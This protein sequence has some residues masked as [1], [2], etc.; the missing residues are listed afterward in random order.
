MEANLPNLQWLS[1]GIDPGIRIVAPKAQRRKKTPTVV[2]RHFSRSD[3]EEQ[4]IE[5]FRQLG[6]I[7]RAAVV[8]IA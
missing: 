7:G 3:E 1:I 2:R 6:A 4:L 5:A 8:V